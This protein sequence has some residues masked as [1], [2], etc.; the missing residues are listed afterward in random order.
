MRYFDSVSLVIRLG[1]VLFCS[2]WIIRKNEVGFIAGGEILKQ[3]L[4]HFTYLFFC[5]LLIHEWMLE[6]RK[7][8]PL[9]YI[10]KDWRLG[11]IDFLWIANSV[12]YVSEGRAR[13]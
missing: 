11:K 2:G 3:R 4:L 10:P 13:L 8:P 6:D 7:A 5:N 1:I 12:P 9:G